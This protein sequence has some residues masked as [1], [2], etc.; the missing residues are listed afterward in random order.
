MTLVIKSSDAAFIS[1]NV[2]SFAAANGRR[3]PE[4]V[5]DHVVPAE[6]LALRREL[7]NLSHQLDQKA[8]DVERL[9][10]DVARAYQDGEAEGREAGRKDADERRSEALAMLE[11]GVGRAVEQFSR[12]LAS[13]ERLSALLAREGLAKVLEASGP[14]TELVLE[15]I[16][17]HVQTLEARSVLR[18]EV[19]SKDFAD[20]TLLRELAG[21][22]GQPALD[23]CASD[24]LA[25]GDC[26]I[27]LRLGALEIG[28]DQQWGRLSAALQDLAEPAPPG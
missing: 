23:V 20:A 14:R 21:A 11:T 22:L 3:P 13:L 4:P 18:I 16:R 1:A 8:A 25:S 28:I 10:A 6:V 12:E 26:L 9:Q 15:T 5:H 7:E 24:R 27:K 17:R 19:S 2:R